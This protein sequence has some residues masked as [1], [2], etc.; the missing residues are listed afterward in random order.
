MSQA[1][2]EALLQQKIGLDPNIIGSNQI[3]R[4]VHQRL[5]AC[6]L[7]DVKTYRLLLETSPE[8][9]DALIETI[10]V[11]ETWL[12][13]DREPFAFL[14][15]Y[16]KTEWLPASPN[17]VLHILSLPCSTGEEPY[18]IAICLLET[19]LQSNNFQI[20]AVDISQKALDY[21][22]EGIYTQKSFR[23]GNLSLR[24]LYFNPVG[25]KYQLKEL[26]RN[27]VRFTRGNILE[28]LSLQ[29]KKPYHVIF[30]RNLFIYFTPAARKRAIQVLSSLLTDRGLLFVGHSETS[31]IP[32]L[33]FVPVSHPLAFAFRKLEQTQDLIKTK[34]LTSQSRLRRREG[35]LSNLSPKPDEKTDVSATS[36]RERTAKKN[37]PLPSPISPSQPT[38]A[39]PESTLETARV[40]A[41][42]GQLNEAATLCETYLSQARVNAEA[43]VLLG[44]VRQAQG[45]EDQAVQCFEKAI[46]LEPN[47]YEALIHLALL[48]EH[49]GDVKGATLI[50]QRIQRI[51]NLYL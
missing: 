39:N 19:G 12:F 22:Q 14:S 38:I 30:C 50:R 11:P 4:A 45:Q 47:C 1:A 40:L 43:Y 36:R 46:Y 23:G 44:Q 17:N 51:K 29:E 34:A 21:A 15:H 49:S 35:K 5:L 13:R 7:S 32:P 24:Q 8:E 37:V 26:V 25:T 10:V 9:L 16:V 20:D 27:S 41:D 2:I 42:R 18:S 28:P 33:K 31:A 3:A 48:K 6:G